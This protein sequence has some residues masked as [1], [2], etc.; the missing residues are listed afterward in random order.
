M[1]GWPEPLE[2]RL[3]LLLGKAA[4]IEL[5][6]IAQ[7]HA[8]L[9][10]GRPRLRRTQCLHQ[11]PAVCRRQRKEQVLV[12]L[13]VEHHVHPVAGFPEIFHVGFR[14]DVRFGEDDG[15]AFAPLQK[16]PERAQ[17]VVLL[18][19]LAHVR[20]LGRNH[21]RDGIHAEAGDAEL[22]PETH[23]LQDLGLHVRIRRV[24]IRLEVVE[25][26]KIPGA[27]LLVI[28]PRRFLRTGK[29]HA[30]VGVGGLF[31]RPDVPIAIF[32]FR[33]ATRLPEPGVPVGRVV[34][35]EIDDDANPALLGA[36]SKLH[37]V[38]E[39]A[40][41]LVDVVIVADVVAVVA[42][43]RGLERHQPDRRDPEPV[44]IVETTHQPLEI[45]DAVAVG[46][47]IGADGQAVDHRVLV[48]EVID[49]GA[50]P[51][52]SVP[53]PAWWRAGSRRARQTGIPDREI[54]YIT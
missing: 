21:K 28:G 33:I 45:A 37:E 18:D 13:K 5:V 11:R 20:A 29:H 49:H 41:T 27:R 44:Q 47:H 9:R 36:V 26:M 4:E 50:R 22:D 52:G 24:E 42:M 54:G 46:I 16:F 38:A 14:Q 35:H 30:F 19:R 23:D 17:H 34:D 32:R 39:R 53:Q 51:S 10:R 15:I 31:V 40:V 48:P 6:V 7:E 12:D 8:P 1:L 3:T 43:R 2:Y 25:A